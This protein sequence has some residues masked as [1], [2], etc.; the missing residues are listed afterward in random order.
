METKMVSKFMQIE[1]FKVLGEGNKEEIDKINKI[2]KILEEK[3]NDAEEG[4]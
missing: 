3:S 2:Q 1:K 4:L